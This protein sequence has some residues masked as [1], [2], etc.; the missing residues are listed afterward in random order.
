[1]VKALREAK[2]HTSWVNPRPDYEQAIIKFVRKALNP[3]GKNPFLKELQEFHAQI[4]PSAMCNALGQ[5]ALKMTVPGVPDLYQGCELWSFRLVDPDN[6]AP[7][8]Y[9]TRSQW[10]GELQDW[11]GN[12]HWGMLE[13]LLENW[14][15]GRIKLYTTYRGLH[16]RRQ[17][18]DLYLQGE[19]NHLNADGRRKNHLCGLIRRGKG[20][21]AITLVPR[22]SMKLTQGKGLP[23]G[24]DIWDDTTVELPEGSAT[25]WRNVYTGEEIEAWLDDEVLRLNVAEV[26]ER[27]P[28][29]ILEAIE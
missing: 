25:R 10:M 22:F 28:V 5:L 13:N 18:Q 27:F 15:D 21:A 3:A 14:R 1:M 29:A 26:F 8:D 12:D 9:E 20:R 7:V 19:Y 17:N 2:E 4:S 16:F 6:R 23:L 11:E 24:K